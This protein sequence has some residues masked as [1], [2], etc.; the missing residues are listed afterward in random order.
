MGLLAPPSAWPFKTPIKK[1]LEK[2]GLQLYT[3]RE[4]LKENFEG[5]LSAVADIGYR[6]VEFAGWYERKPKEIR[7][8]LG[9]LGLESP[10]SHISTRHMRENWGLTIDQALELGNRYLICAYLAPEERRTL[11]DYRRFADLC[12]Q[13]GETARKAGLQF[14]YHNHDFEFPPVGGQVPYD[15]LLRETSA[16]LVKMQMDLYWIAKAGRDPLEYFAKHPGRFPLVHVKDMDDT[17]DQTMVEAGNGIIDFGKIFAR[18]E[19]AGIQ[20][21]Y[22]EHDNP[23]GPPLDS[24]RTSFE[25]LRRLEF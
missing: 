10:S 24:I 13:A 21:F 25:Y 11:D 19:P 15:V 16:D 1:R 12:N 6:E 20:H 4:L 8:L 5:T 22:V 7:A 2:I 23:P 3:V 17:A 18:A 14:G 9:R